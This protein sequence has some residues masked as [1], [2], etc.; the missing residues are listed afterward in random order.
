[1][2]VP[3]GVSAIG[4]GADKCLRFDSM[5]DVQLRARS[6]TLWITVDGDLRDFVLE[7]GQQITIDRDAT[8]LVS[9]MHGAAVIEVLRLPQAVTHSAGR[10]AIEAAWSAVRSH[11]SRLGRAFSRRLERAHRFAARA[12]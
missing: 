11:A 3:V 8:V 5:K 7:R 12:A 2:K 1:M 6:G 4:V 10:R 9:A